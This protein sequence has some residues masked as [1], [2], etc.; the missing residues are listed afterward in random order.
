MTKKVYKGNKAQYRVETRLG[1]GGFGQAWKG[2]VI[3]IKKSNNWIAEPGPNVKDSVVIKW[4]NLQDRYSADDNRIFLQDVNSAINSELYSLKR[5]ASL[6]CVASVYDYGH[7]ELTLSNSSPQAAIFLVEEFLDGTRFDSYL[8]DKFGRGDGPDRTFKGISDPNV[9]LEHA[10]R[11][12]TAVRKIHQQGVIHGDIW[13]ENIMVKN[14]G[15]L[16]FFDLGAS[17]IRDTIFLRPDGLA[18][19]RKDNYCAPERRSGERHGR[20]SDIY[21]LG[22]LFYFMA[23][24]SP[25]RQ[26][27]AD[28]DELKNT[29]VLDIEGS[30]SGLLT[31]N[32]GIA[33]LIARC[34]RYNKDQRIRD[35]DALLNELRLFS[36]PDLCQADQYESIQECVVCLLGSSEI[37]SLFSRML[38]MDSA[39][40]RSRAEDM[41]RGIVEVSG[42]HEDLVLGMS[43]YLSVLGSKDAFLARTTPRFWTTENMG[44]NGRFLSMI[45]LVVQRGTTVKHLMLV[46]ESDRAD[47]KYR[48]ILEAH[49]LAMKQLEYSV[50]GEFQFLCKVVTVDERDQVIREKRWERCYAISGDEVKAIQPV[51]N[52]NNTLRTVRFIRQEN[53]TSEQ[54]LSDMNT[55]LSEATP[56]AKWLGGN[57]FA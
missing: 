3:S 56:L 49:R 35:A 53:T 57:D 43:T 14:S 1:S 19:Q 5:L 18:R 23:T 8:L 38:N 10:T 15:E 31:S 52:K 9:Y 33:D 4:V 13:Q 29:I 44:I 50:A 7:I 6:T 40:L 34:M 21:S 46:C 41:R 45:K 42:D 11:L 26:P 28:I 55:E 2:S 22:G 27:I 12:A 24:G 37:D 51:Y 39:L 25:P 47:P 16:C 20:R 32:C 30:N 17:A 54:V 48:R 36:F